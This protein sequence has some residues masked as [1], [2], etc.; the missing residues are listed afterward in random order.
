MR[1]ELLS[2]LALA[3]SIS[4]VHAAPVKSL[5]PARS[6]SRALKAPSVSAANAHTSS[7]K[8]GKVRLV[9]PTS[10]PNLRVAAVD[11]TT[12]GVSP[13]PTATSLA[14]PGLPKM[15]VPPYTFGEETGNQASARKGTPQETAIQYVAGK[16]KVDPSTLVVA[17][18]STSISSRVTH[19]YL[20][21]TLNHIPI[22][23][24]VHNVNI[25]SKGLVISAGISVPKSELALKAPGAREISAV[26]AVGTVV[27]AFGLGSAVNQISISDDGKSVT[28]TPFANSTVVVSPTLY[29]LPT[30]QVDTAWDMNVRVNFED[31]Y[32]IWVS[33]SSGTILAANSLNSHFGAFYPTPTT[34][35]T[36][37]PTTTATQTSEPTPET[38]L[39]YRAVAF[40]KDSIADGA[41]LFVDPADFSVSPSGWQNAPDANGEYITQGNNV[42]AVI[43]TKSG[44]HAASVN[45]AFDYTFDL[46]KS[47]K[48]SANAV[49]VNAFFVGNRYHDVLYKYGF[50]EQSGNFQNKNF[51]KGGS[52]GDSVLVVVQD[53]SGTNNANF[54]TPTDGNTPEAHFYLATAT[55]PNRD[56]AMD[57][58]V[59][60]HEFTHGLSNRL[61]GGPSNS[62]CLS[63]KV[64][65]CMGEGWSDTVAWWAS[66]KSTDT[67]NTNKVLAKWSFN[68]SNGLRNY[69]YSTSTTTNPLKYS[70]MYSSIEVHNGGEIWAEM[71]YEVYWNMVDQAGFEPDLSQSTSSAGNIRFMLVL[72][73]GMKLQPCNPNFV[74]ARDAIIAA[75]SSINSGAFFC[76]IWKGFAKRGLGKG[77][78]ASSYTN[79]NILPTGC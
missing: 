24:L 57:N 25:D 1:F 31:V 39:S 78:S 20:Q 18:M 29:Y 40:E 47:P 38:G 22:I 3:L 63:T 11:S 26:E 70:N 77:A 17:A 36:P 27:R 19:V 8:V 37:E 58:G 43:G 12:S 50:D 41:A 2:L 30:G 5:H 21:Q 75:D 62:N 44:A 45:K 34:D 55:S 73:E 4:L 28:G 6:T 9:A 51:G 7:T 64:P 56:T 16:I 49:A 15:F 42:N 76:A 74:T 35:P 46:T 53:A 72:V 67:R 48:N 32:N 54:Y 69:P 59:I 68:L 52:G 71:L 79:S 14:N 23:N 60:I 61:T 65:A 13:L 33:S 66:M 10:K